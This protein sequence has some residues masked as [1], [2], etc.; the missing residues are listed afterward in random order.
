MFMKPLMIYAN[1]EVTKL[2]EYSRSYGGAEAIKVPYI[3]S[4]ENEIHLCNPYGKT[5]R[6][7]RKRTKVLI[8]W[9]GEVIT[10]RTF[11]VRCKRADEILKKER[12]QEKAERARQ[13]AIMSEKAK[14]FLTLWRNLLIQ[15]PEKVA[16]YKAKIENSPSNSSRSGNWRNWLRMKAAKHINNG[17]FDLPVGAPELRDVIY[18]I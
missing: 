14:E 12:E 5:Y 4:F 11:K 15:H 9:D 7:M 13:A 18:S 8:H 17:Q 16:K 10:E 3:K 6:V 2:R 1:C